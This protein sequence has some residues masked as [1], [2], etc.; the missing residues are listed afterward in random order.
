ML[1]LISDLIFTIEGIIIGLIFD[2]FRILRKSFK[3]SDIITSFFD[4]SQSLAAT[5]TLQVRPPSVSL[6]SSQF[7][8]IPKFLFV[9]TARS[10]SF[11]YLVI[12][13]NLLAEYPHYHIAVVIIIDRTLFT[14]DIGLLQGPATLR[15]IVHRCYHRREVDTLARFIHEV[16]AALVLLPVVY[17][18]IRNSIGANCLPAHNRAID[19]IPLLCIGC[20][21][22]QQTRQNQ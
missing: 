18:H 20:K 12:R 1:F 13:L 10:K 4:I 16:V 9:G 22:A 21:A 17:S 3:T 11:Q 14:H 2:I 7:T 6:P 5:S 19:L 8:Y 15:H